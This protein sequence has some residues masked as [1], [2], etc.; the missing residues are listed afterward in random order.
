MVQGALTELRVHI[1]ET[2]VSKSGLREQVGQVT[3][4]LRD[5]QSDVGS[6][7]ERLDRVIGARQLQPR[8]QGDLKPP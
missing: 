4:L 1:A 6:V 3:D 2:Y 8:L 7:N 5:V